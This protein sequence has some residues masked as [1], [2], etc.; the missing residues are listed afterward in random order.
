MEIMGGIF[1]LF[2]NGTF[3]LDEDALNTLLDVYK[4]LKAVAL[5]ADTYHRL[6]NNVLI[7][8]LAEIKRL[9]CSVNTVR[10]FNSGL[11]IGQAAAHIKYIELL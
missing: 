7:Q 3:F 8:R 11:L 1:S 2:G 4:I 6:D 9:V 5:A 10:Q